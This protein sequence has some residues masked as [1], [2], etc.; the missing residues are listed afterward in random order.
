[1]E[2][3]THRRSSCRQAG[4]GNNLADVLL[5]S[6]AV[7]EKSACQQ[8]KAAARQVQ[9]KALAILAFLLEVKCFEPLQ[10][11]LGG[12]KGTRVEPPLAQRLFLLAE[13]LEGAWQGMALSRCRL[14]SSVCL[15]D[16]RVSVGFGKCGAL[17][18]KCS[19]AFHWSV[20]GTALQSRQFLPR[21]PS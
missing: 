18:C 16:Q 10:Y 11:L 4:S 15:G 5:L 8:D 19:E 1:M 20:R 2:S 7:P 3:N 9:L 12:S 17:L 21:H 13:H 14:G 6:L